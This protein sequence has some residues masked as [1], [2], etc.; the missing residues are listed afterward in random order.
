MVGSYT[1]T[2]ALPRPLELAIRLLAASVLVL[3]TLHAFQRPIVEPMIPA[4]RA[5]VRLLATEFVIDSAE[6]VQEG[7]NETLRFQANLS[8]PLTF[9]G[10]TLYPFGWSGV[11]PQGGYQV[12]LNLGS[13]LQYCALTLIAVVAWPASHFKEFSMRLALSTPL[14][15]LLLLIHVPFTTVAELWGLLYDDYDPSGFCAWLVWSRFLMGGG[16]LALASLAG[17]LAIAAAKHWA[18]AA[19]RVNN[20]SRARPRSV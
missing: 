1:Q 16:G 11:V 19:L 10:R 18:S 4:F 20:P 3:G 2:R 5:A 6:I 17:A 7:P 12:A 9:A 15:S 13:V 14:L 8:M